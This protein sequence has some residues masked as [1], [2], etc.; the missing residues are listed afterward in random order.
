ML[1]LCAAQVHCRHV[2]LLMSACPH[3]GA[4]AQHFF[5]GQHRPGDVAA[6]IL[7]ASAVRMIRAAM[8]DMCAAQIHPRHV[9]PLA[10]ASPHSGATAQELVSGL[11]GA[12]IHAAASPPVHRTCGDLWPNLQIQNALFP[13]ELTNVSHLIVTMWRVGY[14]ETY[15]TSPVYHAS[16]NA[17]AISRFRVV[18]CAVVL[19]C[20]LTCKHLQRTFMQDLKLM[21]LADGS[22]LHRHF[23]VDAQTEVRPVILQVVCIT[24]PVLATQILRSKHFDK[25]RFHYSFLDPVSSLGSFN[26]PERRFHVMQGRLLIHMFLVWLSMCTPLRK[27]RYVS[28]CI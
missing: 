6:N 21:T 4:T 23:A 26:L 20:S 16:C 14:T 5:P 18:P 8:L 25:I 22:P 11:H 13:C 28:H 2:P 10:S 24:D 12:G 19:K 27:T 3:P 9:P 1:I 7:G 17:W 15:I